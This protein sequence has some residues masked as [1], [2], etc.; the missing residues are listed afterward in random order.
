MTVRTLGVV[1]AGGASRRM[2]GSPKAAMTLGRQTL[3]ERAAERLRPQVDR[4]IVNSNDDLMLDGFPT[5]RD[6]FAER[7]GPLAGILAAMQWAERHEPTALHVASVPV[8]VP[9][10]PLD[11]VARLH[12]AV[13]HD[14]CAIA[15]AGGYPQPVFGLWPVAMGDA[16]RS[17]L[18]TSK[19][20]KI[21]EFVRTQDAGK[22]D[23]GGVEPFENVNTPDDLEAA[24]ARLD[25]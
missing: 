24:R 11:L 20:M 15:V 3:L 23:F 5:V 2:G 14:G 4:M 19:T 18:L 21:M 25:A 17:F 9:Q 6:P 1:L 7:M 13:P 16:L 22:V 8:D 12:G 10:F